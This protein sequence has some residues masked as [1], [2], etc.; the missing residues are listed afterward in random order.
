[1]FIP[2]VRHVPSSPPAH[3]L[4]PD[5][6]QLK[7]KPRRQP[8]IQPCALELTAMLGCW[9]SFSDLSNTNACKESAKALHLCMM[10][11]VRPFSRGSGSSPGLV[12]A[13]T[14][15]LTRLCSAQGAKGKARVSTV[16]YAL[17]KF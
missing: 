12:A 9:A 11:P 4:T 8:H 5:A 3:P 6:P 2:K 7:V 15:A 17:A 10:K 13:W 16:N 1:M 14:V